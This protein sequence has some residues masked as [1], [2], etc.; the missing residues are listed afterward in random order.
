MKATCVQYHNG[1][2]GELFEGEEY[3]V[4]DCPTRLGA[5]KAGLLR[6]AD[7]APEPQEEPVAEQ[8][9]PAPKETVKRAT[10]KV[11]TAR[12]SRGKETR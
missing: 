6:Y 7:P 10:K 1:Q 11:E 4:G 9:P 12:Q 5:L 3:E 8:A 2:F